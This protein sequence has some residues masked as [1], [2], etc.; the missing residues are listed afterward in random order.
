MC[1]KI[2]FT[3]VL[4]QNDFHEK[5]TIEILA[6]VIIKIANRIEELQKGLNFSCISKEFFL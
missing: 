3:K 1:Q 2:I 5:I 4:I 6:K